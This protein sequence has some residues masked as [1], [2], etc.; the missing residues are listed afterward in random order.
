MP[1]VHGDGGVRQSL[2][3]PAV[4][5][6]PA[7]APGDGRLGAAAAAAVRAEGARERSP[8]AAAWRPQA[9]QW[10]VEAEPPPSSLRAG[11][12]YLP[13]SAVVG[14]TEGQLPDAEIR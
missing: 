3:N 2:L 11:T 9:P 5:R 13:A 4:A 1:P 14:V 10:R 8:V 12:A 7:Q 6:R